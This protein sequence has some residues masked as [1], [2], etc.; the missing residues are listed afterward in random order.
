MS[1]FNPYPTFIALPHFTQHPRNQSHQSLSRFLLRTTITPLPQSLPVSITSPQSRLS[2]ILL[3]PLLRRCL[4]R[5]Q[6]HSFRL[7]TL[8]LKTF[9]RTIRYVR[10][11][12]SR[13]ISHLSHMQIITWSRSLLQTETKLS[14]D[15]GR[16]CLHP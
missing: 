14:Q 15:Y 3:M 13:K 1:D 6:T 11:G 2:Q 10:S 12:L 4:L 9:Q 16:R 7:P 5:Y 8:L